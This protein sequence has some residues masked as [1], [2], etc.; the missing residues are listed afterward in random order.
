MKKTFVLMFLV[1]LLF[2]TVIFAA[3]ASEKAITV[4][5]DQKVNLLF[6][7]YPKWNGIT[8]KEPNA[9]GGDWERFMA[10]EF[11]KLHPNV[12][13]EVEILDFSSGPEKVAISLAS[14]Q[15]GNVLH[16]SESRMFEYA[17]QGFLLPLDNH[18][19]AEDRAEYYD[20]ALATASL[21]DGKVYYLPFGSTPIVMMVNKSLFEKA[22]TVNLLPQ[23]PNRTWT[24]EEY[25][26]AVKTTVD[27]LKN[28]YAVPLFANTTTGEA[29]SF[30][31]VWAHG[32]RIVDASTARM[33]VNTPEA[34]AGLAFWK[35]LIDEKLATPGGAGM[36]AGDVW[37]L[38][39]QQIALTAPAGTVNYARALT[40]QATGKAKAFDIELVFMP[41][42]TGVKQVSSGF[43]HGFAV[44]KNDDPNVEHW[45]VEFA[46]FLASDPYADA[47]KAAN[48]FSFKKSQVNMYD[49]S[50]DENMTFA[51]KAMEYQ[52]QNGTSVVGY[53]RLRNEI[54]PYMQ[55]LYLGE[56]SVE[57][58][59]VTV[60]KMG[61]DFLSR[62]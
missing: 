8:G 29:F 21:A 20:G 10:A 51:A 14:G 55:Q 6:W 40:A 35:K 26:K 47:V 61:N 60:E 37:T 52:I 28:V 41:M 19:T 46:K 27:I 31:W 16:D 18:L 49:D 1:L 30:I 3:G 59:A 17:N 2:Q 53:T 33:A 57:E 7:V 48:E 56:I 13:I 42:A 25:Y 11:M 58:F 34:K 39:D 4:Q 43:P 24:I 32:G 15:T 23:N 54:N 50:P 38:F 12:N 22:G 44:F 9:Q 45:S 5:E 62:Q 36:K